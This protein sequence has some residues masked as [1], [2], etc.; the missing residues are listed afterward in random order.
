MNKHFNGNPNN[1]FL[2]Y[3]NPE[4]NN[5]NNYN[6]YLNKNREIMGYHNYNNSNNFIHNNIKEVMLQDIIQEYKVFID[7]GNR[8]TTAFKNPCHFT[9]SFN[10]KSNPEPHILMDFKNVKFIRI[11]KILLPSYKKFK[12]DEPTTDNLV[13][14]KKDDGEEIDVDTNVYGPIRA[15]KGYTNNDVI[16]SDDIQAQLTAKGYTDINYNIFDNNYNQFYFEM[17]KWYTYSGDPT[18]SLLDDD[19]VILNIPELNTN[20]YGTNNYVNGSFS[21]IYVDKEKSD[22]KYEGDIVTPSHEFKNSDLGNIKRLTFQILDKDGVQISFDHIEPDLV[23]NVKDTRHPL[24]KSLQIQIAMVIGVV[25]PT[26][27]KFVQY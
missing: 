11:E 2:G 10:P 7:S 18:Q 27:N 1:N 4:S 6:K 14:I 5:K 25:E 19:Y 13:I 23:Q 12:K 3:S 20:T 8:D 24:N 26:Q 15:A 16:S 9:V 22:Y 17:G 21:P